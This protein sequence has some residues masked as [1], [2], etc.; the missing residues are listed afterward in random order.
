MVFTAIAI[1][2]A[3]AR[4]DPLV[5]LVGAAV[6]MIPASGWAATNRWMTVFALSTGAIA[7][8]ALAIGSRRDSTWRPVAIAA[9]GIS[10]FAAVT[11]S[12]LAV[13][14]ARRLRPR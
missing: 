3:R 9:G 2:F 7:F 5:P 4:R 6:V 10:A 13:G 11:T 14:P 8:V 12:Y 1:V